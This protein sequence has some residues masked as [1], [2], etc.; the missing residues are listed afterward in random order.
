[1]PADGLCVWPAFLPSPFPVLSPQPYPRT[2]P[3]H[4]CSLLRCCSIEQHPAQHPANTVPATCLGPPSSQAPWG[5]LSRVCLWILRGNQ[6]P[7]GE[8]V[9][10]LRGFPRT[11]RLIL[12]CD[13]ILPERNPF[14]GSSSPQAGVLGHWPHRQGPEPWAYKPFV[15]VVV[16]PLSPV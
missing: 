12:R 6:E 10:S 13:D 15:V 2:A 11:Y 16:Q 3:P 4:P 7:M 9:E 1:M 14:P 8:P 5:P